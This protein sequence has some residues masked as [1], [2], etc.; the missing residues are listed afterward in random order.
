MSKPKA[1]PSRKVREDRLDYS[2]HQE[3]GADCDAEVLR[4]LGHGLIPSNGD[5]PEVQD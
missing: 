3:D 4:D 5:E 1:P 2:T